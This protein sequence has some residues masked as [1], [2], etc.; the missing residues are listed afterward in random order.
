MVSGF[1]YSEIVKVAAPELIISVTALV[2]LTNDLLKM[3]AAPRRK[4]FLV[5]GALAGL[6]CV[7]A[8]IWL[9]VMNQPPHA[10]ASSG[11]PSL[12]LG[13]YTDDSLVRLV[14]VAI[15]VMTAFTI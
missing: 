13:M 8:A 11:L 10:A 9:L 4:R 1:S 14:K 12:L 7:L 5:G 3:R 2:V 15:L 6:G